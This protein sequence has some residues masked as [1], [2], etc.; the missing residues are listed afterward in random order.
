MFQWYI[1]VNIS[2]TFIYIIIFAVIFQPMMYVFQFS[3][4]SHNFHVR[5]VTG[6]TIKLNIIIEPIVQVTV[7]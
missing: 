3:F 1:M 5:L 2:D 4:E 6:I 7:E